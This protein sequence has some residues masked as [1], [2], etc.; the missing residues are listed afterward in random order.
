MNYPHNLELEFSEC[1]NGCAPND[2][3]VLSGKDM[4][5]G[6]PG[7]FDVCR[8][9]TCGLERTN[10]R[11]T[12]DTIGIYYPDNYGPYQ[13]K[14]KLL[15]PHPRKSKL[16][17]LII[18]V[19][20]LKARQLPAV[21]PGRMLEIGCSSGAYM[22]EARSNGWAVDGVEFSDKVALIARG[23]GFDVKSGAIE[24]VDLESDAYDMIVAWMVIEHLHDPI[25]VLKK[26]NSAI[27]P[28][29]YLVASVPDTKSLAKFLFK[30][31]CYDL[32]LP[33]HLYHFTP[34]T[35]ELIL[36]KS[37]WV[38]ERVIWQR[39]CNTLLNSFEYWA[40]EKNKP[41][42]IKIATWLK[43]SNKAA[44]YVRLMLNII[45]GVTRLSGRIEI[46]ARPVK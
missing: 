10:P 32:H 3:V 43:S 15:S 6:I 17:K 4:L 26:L 5:H 41:Y 19:F 2:K 27:K 39:N 20:G 35:L 45:L 13:S 33:N 40:I 31:F 21:E 46:W 1:P 44:A 28:R 25:K 18:K 12:Q 14:K 37:G 23:Q 16:N 9:M 8:C 38:L 34:N 30:E 11:P 29:G 7:R 42:I 24:S 36:S 22:Q